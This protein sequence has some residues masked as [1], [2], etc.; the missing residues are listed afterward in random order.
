METRYTILI[1]D[2]EEFIINS[3]KRLLH[4]DGYRI[5]TALNSIDGYKI[6]K[7][8]HVQLVI[9][10]QRM[11]G[12]SGTEFLARIRNDF[13]DVIR[14]IISGYTDV[15]SITESINRGDIFKFFYKP[16]DENNLRLEIKHC[17]DQYVL[18]NKNRE[19]NEIIENKNRELEIIKDELVR[20]NQNLETIVEQRTKGLEIQNQALELVRV[21]FED[22]PLPV[23]C[24]SADGMIAMLNRKASTLEHENFKFEPGRNIGEFLPGNIKEPFDRTINSGEQ[25]IIDDCYV[26]GMKC[27]ILIAPLK[28]RFAGKCFTFILI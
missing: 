26:M 16:W 5:L 23:L 2:D 20:I 21:I 3:L 7:E 4:R 6:L 14:T 12:E 11:P 13:P 27:K 17:I 15:D 25:N 24:I 8:N 19:L 1:V 28:G 9:S 10:D 22:M 18:I